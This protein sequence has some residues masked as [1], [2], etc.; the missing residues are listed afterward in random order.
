MLKFLDFDKPFK[1]NI[2]ASDFSIRQVRMQDARPIAY[3]SKKLDGCQR[4]WL[5]HEKEFF[6]VVHCL[7]TWQPKTKI[8]LDNVSLKYFETRVQMSAKFLRLQDTLGVMN[9]DLIHKPRRDNVVLNA[10]NRQEEF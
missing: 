7:K 5:T 6:G 2:D 9:L 10:L 3:E 1:V 8:Y 4:K